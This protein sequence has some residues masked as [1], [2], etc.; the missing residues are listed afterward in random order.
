MV[1]YTDNDIKQNGWR[2]AFLCVVGFAAERFWDLAIHGRKGFNALAWH[3]VTSVTIRDVVVNGKAKAEVDVDVPRPDA[4]LA[5][6]VARAVC[7]R[8]QKAGFF[9]L[10]AIR[11]QANDAATEEKDRKKS[12]GEHDLIG[13]RRSLKGRS[14]IEVKLRTVKKD[15]FLPNVRR[16]IQNS[17]HKLWPAA[18]AKPNHGWAERVVVLVRFSHAEAEDWEIYCEALS[19]GHKN[20][21][22]NWEPLF[23]WDE[24]L[25]A[26]QDRT[27]RGTASL[28]QLSHSILNPR[29]RVRSQWRRG[30]PP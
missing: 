29:H 3:S 12:V 5:Y 7:L 28:R 19:V 26:L 8:L 30:P 2:V 17:A 25:P 22:E 18:T 10:D 16:Q 21:P 20:L 14:S 4:E 1:S 9:L 27:A 13:E 11:P 23:G 15:S 24:S 6:R